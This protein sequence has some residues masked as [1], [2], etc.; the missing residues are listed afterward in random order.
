MVVVVVERFNIY[1]N[2]QLMVI[3][4]IIIIIILKKRNQ[5]SFVCIFFHT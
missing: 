4:I 5:F 1:D 2:H 3:I